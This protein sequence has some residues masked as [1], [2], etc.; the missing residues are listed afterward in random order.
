MTYK[1]AA[2]GNDQGGGKAVILGDP[3][4]LRTDDA[5]PGLRPVRRRARRPLPHRR[6]RRHHPGRHG[7]DPHGDPARQRHQ[8]GTGRLGRPVAG[9]RLGVLWAMRAVAER[10]WG[11]PVARRPPRVHQ[12]RRQGR[13]RPGRPPPREGAR[14]TVADVRADAVAAVVDAHRRRGGAAR[15]APTRCACDVFA[16]CALGAALSADHDPGAAPRRQ[17]SDRPTTSSPPRGRPADPATGCAVRPRLRR[18]RRR[19][20]Q[21]R[22]RAR[23]LRSG[24]CRRAHPGDPRHGAPRARPRR[25]EAITTAAAADLLAER[26]I[27]AARRSSSAG[28]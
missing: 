12:R 23:W 5:D 3:P 10:L 1:H 21:H 6:G 2:G 16:P 26:R 15:A 22:P 11:E 13:R 25:A 17:W 9:H 7:P 28:D 4:T 14:L 20:D 27:E 24:P 8:R 19:S 18:Q